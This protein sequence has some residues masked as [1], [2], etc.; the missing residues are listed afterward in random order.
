MD[1]QIDYVCRHTNYTALEAETH[2][3]AHGSVEKVIQIY[4]N[5]PAKNEIKRTT[6]QSMFHEIT[7]LMEQVKGSTPR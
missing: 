4:L 3:R 6:N 5:V 7:K 2:L 1:D